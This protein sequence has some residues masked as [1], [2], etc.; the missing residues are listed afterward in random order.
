MYFKRLEL[1][2]FK[3]FAEPCTIDFHEGI[4]CIVGPNGSG[5]SN[6]SDAIRWVLG[7][8]SPKALR[9]GKME[10]VIFSGTASR[11]PRGMAEVTL[12]I[13]NEESILDIEYKEVAITRRMY[14]SGE[15]EYLINGNNCRLKD[16]RNLIMD[17]GIG[18]DGYSIIGQGK[19]AEIVS[20]RPETR[21]EIFEEAAGIVAYKT[22]KQETTRKLEGTRN[23]L[24]RIEDIIA[25]IENRIGSLKKE[26]EN[27]KRYL[28]LKDRYKD[29]EI[30]ITLRNINSIIKTSDQYKADII[31]LGNEIDNLLA[32]KDEEDKISSNL[33]SQNMN[34]DSR[35]KKANEKRIYLVEKINNITGES[36]LSREKLNSLVKD[37][38]RIDNEIDNITIKI[39]EL[40]K[41]KDIIE[42]EMKDIEAEK[43]KS[44]ERLESQKL[45]FQS[46]LLESK[47]IA[48][49]IN[50]NKDKIIELNNK[51]ASGI[52]EVRSYENYKQ[53]LEN[54]QLKIEEENRELESRQKET[55]ETV[56][57]FQKNLKKMETEKSHILKE[58]FDLQDDIKASEEKEQTLKF[59]VED[60]R[61]TNSKNEARLRTF[62]EMEQ[63]YE[64]Y[65]SA[66]KYI[67]RAG[68]KGIEGVVGD[69]MEV[70]KGLETAVETAL[71][72]GMQNIIVKD[73][74]SARN[75]ITALKINKSGRLTFL[76][77]GSVK[78]GNIKV[79]TSLKNHPGYRGMAVDLIS[80][81]SKYRNIFEYLL[82]R[83]AII[84]NLNSAIQLSKTSGRGIRFVT[85]DGEVIN[86]S[87]AITG[88]K[89][90]NQS[91]NLL[92][93]KNEILNLKNIISQSQESLKEKT[94][95]LNILSDEN[96]ELNA[97]ILNNREKSREIELDIARVNEK[98]SADNKTSL[99]IK[100]RIEKNILEINEINKELSNMDKIIEKIMRDSE[101]FQ[102]EIDKIDEKVNIL[103]ANTQ[104]RND[105]EAKANS[106]VTEAKVKVEALT[107][108]LL[109]KENIL[110][111][112]KDELESLK[113]QNDI[114]EKELLDIR[115]Q[116]SELTAGYKG[117][118]S[119]VINLEKDREKLEIDIQNL[120]SDK[121]KISEALNDANEN[122]KIFEESLSKFRDEKYRLEI[123]ETRNETQVENMKEKLWNE[124]EVSYAQAKSL[125]KD[126][127]VM[128]PAIKE[129]REI[130]K[131]IREIGDV[132]IGAIKEFQE[133][134]QRYTFL[135]EQRQDVVI[136]MEELQ[137]IIDDLEK[138]I[139]RS[140]KDNFNKVEQNFEN[141]FKEL[142]GG[143]HAE[144]R[145]EDEKEPLTS[146]IEIVAQPPGKRLQNLNLM[147]GGEKTMT[148]IALMFAVLKTKP[149]PFCI[150][151]EVEAAL[152]DEN[153]EK[154][155][156]Y[157]KNFKETQFALITHQKAT[158]EHGD[159][160]YGV[161]MPERGISKMLSL[162]MG[163][164]DENEYIS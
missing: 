95:L 2:G 87:G 140:F 125:W 36:K 43:E 64:G 92:A 49:Q 56:D 164:Y 6:I 133:T 159:S 35:L 111:R 48:N 145:L 89:Y 160:L 76:P 31:A 134:S 124:F 85:L 61:V 24:N 126:N 84:D 156:A 54:R 123:R 77:I 137:S 153:I 115:N 5:K 101:S 130:K 62:E 15:S 150:L 132:N 21:R 116:R 51:M 42:S 105:N 37:E 78:S 52:S 33:Y 65:N 17:T 83:V 23:N 139:T 16:I 69:M 103:T 67:M 109:A 107:E 158:M 68:I 163:D 7:E 47:E 32:K 104:S 8:Q 28:E 138:T 44:N 129:S 152:D 148:A 110:N 98:I 81:E 147:S 57:D 45:L 29:L 60:L 11:N 40:K 75:A 27:A 59:E 39:D 41:E 88:G 90:K 58:I 91:A 80:F 99:D 72:A 144:L 55:D 108:K 70:P 4:T 38:N 71:G 161:T 82:G 112:I 151:D 131:E 143:G 53:T 63:N 135:T 118:D 96:R 154:F 114:K 79:D 121:V 66:V 30:N 1:H 34:L 14:R 20:S 106:N 141:V 100:T 73:D 19:I 12:V 146:G 162:R 86:T 25:E 120:N 155:S 136:A 50:D 74:I 102:I 122:L 26:S 119:E 149:T 9:G 46:I 128:T 10:E 94:K 157:L 93:R 113:K 97:K 142:F 22:K 3:S 18:V 127:F 13:D 117:S